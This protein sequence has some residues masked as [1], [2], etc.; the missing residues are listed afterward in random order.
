MNSEVELDNIIEV[1]NK[2]NKIGIFTHISPDG[3]AIGSSLGLYL[4]LKQL[5]K[6]VDIIT[7]EFAKCFNFLSS[8]NEIKTTTNKKYDLA[9]AL[10]CAAKNRLY[11]PKQSFDKSTYTIAIDHH[12]SNTFF[13]KLNYVEANSPAVCQTLAKILKRLNINMT[14]EIGECLIAGLITDSG[15]FRYDTVNN[16]TF[17]LAS[18][19]LDIGV[20][21]SDI[22]FKTF[23]LKTK[24]Q[25]DLT[26]IAASRLKFYFKNRIALTYIT[27][28]DIKK[29]KAQTGEHEGIVNIGRNIEGVEVSVLI[30]E[31]KDGTYKI[32]LRSNQTIDVSEV[33][34]ALDGGGHSKAAGCTLNLPLE[35][36]IKKLLKEIE[37]K[38]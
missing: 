19:M 32:S 2:A 14:K 7:D 31:D 8:I 35:E 23:D 37:K 26:T 20:E 29:T 13:A 21:I 16:E 18:S 17:E 1:I 24:S 27:Q 34:K 25:F 30:R 11:D 12:S 9:I 10:D 5:K 33:A 38:L 3:D 15:G 6:E 4:G 36:V 28:E 22:Y